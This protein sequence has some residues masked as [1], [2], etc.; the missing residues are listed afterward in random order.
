MD[1]GRAN[2]LDY[3]LGN[4]SPELKK[5]IS[6]LQTEILGLKGKVKE[7]ENRQIL[8][9]SLRLAGITGRGTTLG[10]KPLPDHL[11]IAVYFIFGPPESPE[12][13]FDQIQE[14]GLAFGLSP[15][16]YQELMAVGSNEIVIHEVKPENSRLKPGEQFPI[17]FLKEEKLNG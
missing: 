10:K 9:M 3:A 13:T 5:Y 12:R 1:D 16:K 7:L 6:G 15:E 4:I 11:G 8:H 14:F 2:S 17:E